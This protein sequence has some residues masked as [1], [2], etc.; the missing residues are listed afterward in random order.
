VLSQ[1]VILV[2]GLGTRLGELTA[3]TPKPLLPVAGRPFVEHL[4]QE[5]SRYGFRRSRKP[6]TDGRSL[7]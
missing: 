2:G 6:M 4:V 7:V 5:L 3:Q 1:A